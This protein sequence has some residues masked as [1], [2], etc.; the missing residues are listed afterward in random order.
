MIDNQNINDQNKMPVSTQQLSAEHYMAEK[1]LISCLL[2]DPESV[3][4][5]TDLNLNQ[6]DF[7]NKKLAIIFKEF[8]DLI[9]L[10]AGVDFIT[11]VDSLT[12]KNLLDRIGGK[13]F[14]M[15]IFEEQASSVNI[16][17]YAQIIKDRSIFRKVKN[18]SKELEQLSLSADL[19]KEQLLDLV[20]ST[21]FKL[22]DDALLNEATPIQ[23][24]VLD[25]LKSIKNKEDISSSITKSLFNGLDQKVEG[26]TPGQL[27]VLAARPSMGKTSL[28]L[29]IAE[30]VASYYKE[31][32]VI[33]SLE[34]LKKELTTRIISSKSEVS[35]SKFKKNQFTSNELTKI[36]KAA[37]ECSNL[38][39]HIDDN[40]NLNVHQIRNKCFRIKAQ[41]KKLRMVVIDYLQLLQLA[42]TKQNKADLVGDLTR[43]LKLLAK[44]LECPVL[45]LSQLNR[46]VEARENKRPL[47]ADLRDSG[48]IEQDADMVM[49]I[50]RESFY[51]DQCENPN[52]AEIILAKN[53]NGEVGKVYLGWDGQYTKFSDTIN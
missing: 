15:E 31:P 21:V 50:Y 24:S 48:A 47:L 44:E 10:G 30:N 8:T 33:F 52:Q 45:V 22:N 36:A 37:Q 5:L 40:S 26:F 16:Y 23:N 12:K 35:S 49:F 17:H 7:F 41:H 53:R 27:I 25:I 13:K 28:A 1:A 32:V 51:N 2:I 18:V 39:I 42:D 4:E 19:N 46:G 3:Y 11:I 38:S 29:N 14:L 34:M 6:G 43:S 9:E 20:N